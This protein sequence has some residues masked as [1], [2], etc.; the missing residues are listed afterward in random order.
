MPSLKDKITDLMLDLLD[1]IEKLSD[2]DLGSDDMKKFSAV[3][4]RGI[5]KTQ[6]Q[7][8]IGFYKKAILL[9]HDIVTMVLSNTSHNITCVE[10]ELEKKI[11]DVIFH[12][13]FSDEPDKRQLIRNDVA[14][15]LKRLKIQKKHLF[16]T[17]FNGIIAKQ[18]WDFGWI[19]FLPNRD[20]LI[21]YAETN[22]DD[23]ETIFSFI[24]D[25][26]VY[27]ALEVH[28]S[29]DATAKSLAYDLLM[30][31]LNALTIFGEIAFLPPIQKSSILLYNNHFHCIKELVESPKNAFDLDNL[32]SNNSEV[33][34]KLSQLLK[35][36]DEDRLEMESKI[37]IA[38]DWFGEAMKELSR[39]EKLLKFVFCLES[40]LLGN[41]GCLK[42]NIAERAA[43]IYSKKF[44]VRNE[45]FGIVSNAYNFRNEIVH[46]G[47]LT[48]N[49]QQ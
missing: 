41:E 45:I 12:V 29:T 42:Q 23:K 4:W 9:I 3:H 14:D 10:E 49:L 43:L 48:G 37:L 5:G 19:T 22:Y 1:H 18:K 30:K 28:A 36:D 20:S 17:G 47:K 2:S 44:E 26:G 25:S 34:E 16:F 24:P 27:I 8:G 38:L 32:Y 15:L 7:I 46:S 13:V 35:K 21:Q 39:Q 11:D 31:H 33:T 40:L 6:N